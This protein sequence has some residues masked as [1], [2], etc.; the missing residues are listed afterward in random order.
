MERVAFTNSFQS[1]PKTVDHTMLPKGINA[2]VGTGRVETA[3]LSQPW[4]DDFL[5]AF[6]Q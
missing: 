3:A 1:E 5:I 6:D 4:T 2:I